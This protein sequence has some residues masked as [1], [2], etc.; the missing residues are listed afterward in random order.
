MAADDRGSRDRPTKF[1]KGGHPILAE[2]YDLEDS[3]H[4]IPTLL[5]S[6]HSLLAILLTV[7][8]LPHRPVILRPDDYLSDLCRLLLAPG[9]HCPDGQYRP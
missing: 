4:L 2:V 3:S 6:T 8:A 9:W 1:Q 7:F 5:L